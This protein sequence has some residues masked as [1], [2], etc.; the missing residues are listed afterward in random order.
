MTTQ[1]TLKKWFQ[2]PIKN[3]DKIIENRLEWGADRCEYLVEQ[4]KELDAVALYEE[5]S[6]WVNTPDNEDYG[7]LLLELI[8]AV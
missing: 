3:A 1:R 4:G 5:Y 7:Y 8:S 6:E 2:D